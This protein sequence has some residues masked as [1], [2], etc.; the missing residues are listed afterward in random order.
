M[1]P[2]NNQKAIHTHL[3]IPYHNT[4]MPRPT[5]MYVTIPLS[6]CTHTN[7]RIPT[8]PPTHSLPLLLSAT[9]LLTRQQS[10]SVSAARKA[11]P[12]VAL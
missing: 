8:Y 2:A 5:H 7:T 6:F 10:G 1:D 11:G 4:V 12:E 9:P 3:T